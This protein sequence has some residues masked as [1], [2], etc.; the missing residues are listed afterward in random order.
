MDSDN[1]GVADGA[2]NTVTVDDILA[3]SQTGG[4]ICGNDIAYSITRAGAFEGSSID[5][6]CDDLDQMVTVRV[7]AYLTDGNGNVYTNGAGESYR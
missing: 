7:Y 5:V 2:M 3:D 4:S 6:T 1:D